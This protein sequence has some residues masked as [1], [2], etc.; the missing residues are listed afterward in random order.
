MD[1]RHRGARAKTLAELVDVY[2]EWREYNDKPIVTIQGCLGRC[3]VG[4][5]DPCQAAERIRAG[6]T[7][8]NHDL[9]SPTRPGRLKPSK[10]RLRSFHLLARPDRIADD[11]TGAS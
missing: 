11:S 10:L 2:L 1:G 4:L 7:W 3:E 6:A 9:V 8:Q 5:P